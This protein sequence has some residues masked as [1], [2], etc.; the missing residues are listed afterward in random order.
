[1]VVTTLLSTCARSSDSSVDNKN[2][3]SVLIAKVDAL[4]GKLNSNAFSYDINLRAEVSA[5]LTKQKMLLEQLKMFEM[6]LLEIESRTYNNLKSNS[7]QAPINYNESIKSLREEFQLLF[8]SSNDFQSIALA[9]VKSSTE[10]AIG[11]AEHFVY[12]LIYSFT[13][14]FALAGV[15]ATWKGSKVAQD[16]NEAK[17]KVSNL[18]KL[19]SDVSEKAKN[20]EKEYDGLD[21]KVSKNIEELEE[22]KED[23]IE[24]REELKSMH[25]LMDFRENFQKYM[26]NESKSEAKNIISIGT[27]LL[28]K[29][30]KLED[31]FDN[32]ANTSYVAS[33]LGYLF[34]KLGDYLN[35]Y[36]YFLLSKEVNVKNLLDRYHNVACLAAKLYI[37][38]GKKD[39]QYLSE[40]RKNYMELTKYSDE[41]SALREDEY[42]EQIIDEMEK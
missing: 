30:E 4:E 27:S 11:S 34:Y 23:F 12:W 3:I 5:S 16:S 7:S 29:I 42:F 28:S 36:K 17:Q 2:E 9:D 37:D 35:S 25:A 32:K 19:V 14:I 41:L 15:Y 24:M 39:K 22:I 40:A 6:R 38:S 20:A 26:T 31:T 10:R 8:K 13:A 33:V 1:M 21:S 18:D